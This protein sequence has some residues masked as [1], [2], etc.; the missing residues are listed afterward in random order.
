MAAGRAPKTISDEVP[1]STVLKYVRDFMWFGLDWRMLDAT[2]QV[3]KILQ[4]CY[5]IVGTVVYRAI[6][7]DTKMGYDTQKWMDCLSQK[8]GFDVCMD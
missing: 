5:T 3:L 6:A 1:I 2:L 4:V 7:V 8:G